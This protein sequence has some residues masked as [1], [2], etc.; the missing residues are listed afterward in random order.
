MDG[1]WEWAA[2]GPWWALGCWGGRGA[3]PQAPPV[4]GL[5]MAVGR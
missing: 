2:S 3:Y 1:G 4:V 5:A